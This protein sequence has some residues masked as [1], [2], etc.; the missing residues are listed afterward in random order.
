MLGEK[1]WKIERGEGRR[2]YESERD[3]EKHPA[4]LFT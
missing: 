3:Y 1:E 2:E 4:R